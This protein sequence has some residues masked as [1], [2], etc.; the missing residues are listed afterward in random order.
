MNKKLIINPGTSEIDNATEQ[1]A[2]E[3]IEQYVKDCEIGGLTFVRVPENDYGDG[4]FAF[5]VCKGK[6]C[7]EIQMPGLPLDKVRYVGSEGQ[8][9]WDFPRLYVDD[10]SWIWL[11]AIRHESDFKEVDE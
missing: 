2:V 7:H 1:N 11:F 9:I 4:R 10:S 3:N 5:K 6:V 8:N